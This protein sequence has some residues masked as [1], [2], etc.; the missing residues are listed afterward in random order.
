[1]WKAGA[2]AEVDGED[3]VERRPRRMKRGAPPPPATPP[4]LNWGQR[5]KINLKFFRF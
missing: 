2:K 5:E 4:A 3:G 1:L